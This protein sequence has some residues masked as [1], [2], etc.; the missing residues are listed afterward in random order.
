VRTY[1]PAIAFFAAAG[2][3]FEWKHFSHD[4]PV[5]MPERLK[6][7]RFDAQEPE[8]FVA[9][10]LEGEVRHRPPTGIEI[11]RLD[12]PWSFGAIAAV[13]RAVYGD[14]DHAA[15]LQ[16]VVADE[17][18]E[19]PDSLSLYAAFEGDRPVSVGWMRHRRGNSFGSLWG[20][21][22][23]AEYR[24]RGLYASLVAARAAEARERGCRWLTVDCSP[25]SLPILERRGFRRL[26][27]IT[28]FIWS[29]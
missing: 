16:R 29:S 22:T 27:V 15:W 8:T 10:D 20:G 23:L 7:A 25:M 3:S 21:S 9:L 28:P 24:G 19:S 18:R 14:P 12:D 13:N 11:R 1:A 6:A 26:A 17:K 5:D 4:R 2:R